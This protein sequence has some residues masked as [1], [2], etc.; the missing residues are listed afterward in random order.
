VSTAAPEPIRQDVCPLC[1]G[2]NA[3]GLAAGASTCWCFAARIPAA[4]L[5]RVPAGARDRSC[6]C[7]ACAAADVSTTTTTTATAADTPR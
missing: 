7:Q 3:C 5:E 4:V 2:S 1:G 6:I